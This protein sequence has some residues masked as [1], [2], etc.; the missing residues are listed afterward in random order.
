MWEIL[1]GPSVLYNL[2]TF[3][4]KNM[5]LCFY[6]FFCFLLKIVL[7]TICLGYGNSFMQTCFYYLSL[8]Y[9]CEV[10]AMSVNGVELLIFNN[11]M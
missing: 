7:H 6:C 11:G 5:V 1:W 10:T 8:E 9:I 4:H 3:V 2:G